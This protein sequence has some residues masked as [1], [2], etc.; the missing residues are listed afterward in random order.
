MPHSVEGSLFKIAANLRDVNPVNTK[1]LYNI[2]TM[3]AQRRRRWAEVVQC[4]TNVLWL[5]VKST[6]GCESRFRVQSES[7]NRLTVGLLLS[8]QNIKRQGST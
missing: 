7:F 4:Y 1:N 6:L 3:L 2:C 8:I 5:L